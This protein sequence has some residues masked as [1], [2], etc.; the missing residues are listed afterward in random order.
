[1]WYDED[2]ETHEDFSWTDKYVCCYRIL[3]NSRRLEWH[4]NDERHGGV[5]T[6]YL[7]LYAQ[8]RQQH[9]R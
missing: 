5:G 3:A 7:E 9:A 8:I 2:A 1:M 4:S 6:C